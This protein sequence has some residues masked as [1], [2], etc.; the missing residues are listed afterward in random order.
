LLCKATASDSPPPPFTEVFANLCDL[1]LLHNVIGLPTLVHPA[2]GLTGE[3]RRVS[4]GDVRVVKLF[5]MVATEKKFL[6]KCGRSAEWKKF[7]L[8]CVTR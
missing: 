3:A 5:S 2:V 7:W 1:H 8:S 4:D 6:L